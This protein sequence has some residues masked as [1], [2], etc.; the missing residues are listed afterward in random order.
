MG[1]L[2]TQDLGH[3]CEVPA[4]GNTVMCSDLVCS[5]LS[6]E[7]LSTWPEVVG[8]RRGGERRWEGRENKGG[9]ERKGE[10]EREVG[11]KSK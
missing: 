10:R 9:R 2:Y 5:F 1:Q 6:S 8:E 11:K 3:P 4:L 7:V